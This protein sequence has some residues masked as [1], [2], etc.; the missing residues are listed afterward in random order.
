MRK[1]GPIDALLSKTLQAVLGATMMQPD[2]WWY[3]SDLARHL[4]RSPSSLQEPLAALA[5]SGVLRR[6]QDGNRVYFQPDP[7]CPFLS[8]LQGIIV[9]TVGLADLLRDLLEPLESDIDS[10]FVYGSV[11]RAEELSS[12]DIDLMVIGKAGLADIAPA[13]RQAE[14][15][16]NRPVNATVYTPAEFA[17]KLKAKNHFLGAVLDEE[18]LFVVGNEHDLEQ[19]TRGKA[20]PP[21]HH[22]QGGA[23]RSPRRR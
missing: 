5:R 7:D 16:L 3:L 8:E 19:A 21:A 6:R 9:K 23:R 1:S 10:A 13:L 12:S 17:K 4:D 18:K 22:K 11:A 14:E 15:R 2:R 20:G